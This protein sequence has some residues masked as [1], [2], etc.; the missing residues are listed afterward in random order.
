MVP[1]L[2]DTDTSGKGR[3]RSRHR[4]HPLPGIAIGV[5]AEGRGYFFLGNGERASA[6]NTALA[7]CSAPLAVITTSPVVMAGL[8]LKRTATSPVKR[9]VVGSNPTRQANLPVAQ[10]I[11]HLR[12]VLAP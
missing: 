6:L 1:A 11:E 9:E 7:S 12:A 10:R 2:K 4:V 3:S 8:A 5:D